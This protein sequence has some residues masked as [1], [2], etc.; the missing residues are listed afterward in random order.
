M[1]FKFKRFYLTNFLGIWCSVVKTFSFI[2][3]V[4]LDNELIEHELDHVVIGISNSNPVLNPAEAS[5]FDWKTIENIKKEMKTKNG[6]YLKDGF[7]VDSDETEEEVSCDVDEEE[8]E[9]LELQEDDADEEQIELEDDD[10]ELSCGS[11]LE[12]EE[13]TYSD[14]D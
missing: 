1:G 9:L 11:E 6:E 8:E 2:Y 4:A 7:V 14:D 13:Y 3:D 12:E 10:I 5:D